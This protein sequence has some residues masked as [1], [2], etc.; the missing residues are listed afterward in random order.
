MQWSFNSHDKHI[1]TG[2]FNTIL[3]DDRNQ[4]TDTR[5]MLEV[6]YEPKLSSTLQSLSRAHLDYYK[7]TGAISAQRDPEIGGLSIETFTGLWAGVEERF[8]YTPSLPIRVTFGGE[9][10]NHFMANEFASDEVVVAPL[11]Q[12]V[13]L[14]DHRSFQVGA[15]YAVADAALSKAVKLSVGGRYD[16]YSTFGQSFNPRVALIVRPYDGGNIKIMFG[17]AF[18]APSVYELYFQTPGSQIANPSLQSESMYS[19]EV[20]YSHRF[21]PT[22]TGLV[23]VYENFIQNLIAQRSVEDAGAGIQVVQYANTTTPVATMGA[24]RRSR[25]EWKDLAGWRPPRTRSHARCI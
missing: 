17:K 20:E 15:G 21:T 1:P 14:D 13:Y 3:G 11:T 25:R 18:R 10:Q 9:L 7:Y 24:R 16:A 2:Q 23:T 4:Q 5:G 19:G 22:I 8:V 6:K 12:S